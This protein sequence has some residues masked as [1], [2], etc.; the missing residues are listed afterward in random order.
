MLFQQERR[1]LL[2]QGAGHVL[3]F[4]ERHQLVLVLGSEHPFEG[5]AR[6]LQPPLTQGLAI[7]PTQ[8]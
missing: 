5:I 1:Q 4:R 2:A 3:P 6:T 7:L 8:S